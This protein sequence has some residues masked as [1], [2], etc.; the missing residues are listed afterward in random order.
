M[1]GQSLFTKDGVNPRYQGEDMIS[2]ADERSSIASSTKYVGT[3][4]I[5]FAGTCS[6]AAARVQ[7]QKEKS[8]CRR[9]NIWLL[10]HANNGK[11]RSML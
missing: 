7:S 2:E 4:R 9:D 11:C 1:R 5:H 8:G 10:A 3:T 6:A